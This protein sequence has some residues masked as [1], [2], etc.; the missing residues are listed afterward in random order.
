M[1][2]NK[3]LGGKLAQKQTQYGFSLAGAETDAE[4][5]NKEEKEELTLAHQSFLQLMIR[6]LPL[7]A[8][9]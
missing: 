7:S 3:P 6:T 2:F 4:V 1:W 9:S 8:M 5:T